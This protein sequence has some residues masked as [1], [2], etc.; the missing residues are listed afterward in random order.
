MISLSNIRI[1][2]A[3]IALVFRIVVFCSINTLLKLV[4]DGLV[5]QLIS[6][7]NPLSLSFA[8]A[9]DI[10]IHLMRIID[11]A[12][13]LSTRTELESL[14]IHNA[15][16]QQAVHETVI[17]QVLMPSEGYLRHLCVNHRLIVD[18]NQSSTF[19][20]LIAKIFKICPSHD[21]MVDFLCELPVFLA[22]PSCL[23]HFESFDTTL[24][25]PTEMLEVQ[26]E[27]TRGGGRMLRR[28][29]QVLRSLRTEGIEDVFE[30]RLPDIG[31][32]SDRAGVR[33]SISTTELHRDLLV[34]NLSAC[35]MLPNLTRTTRTQTLEDIM[36]SRKIILVAIWTVSQKID[37]PRQ[38]VMNC[39]FPPTQEDIITSSTLSER[40]SAHKF[41]L[42][43]PVRVKYNKLGVGSLFLR[44]ISFLWVR[45][46][47]SVS[48]IMQTP[49]IP[50]TFATPLC[51]TIASKFVAQFYS[52]MASHPIEL[53]RLY[54]EN[55][56]RVEQNGDDTFITRGTQEIRVFY[57]TAHP[58]EMAENFVQAVQFE[59]FVHVTVEG[60]MKQHQHPNRSFVHN[61][62]LQ[63]MNDTKK[64]FYIIREILHI[65]HPPVNPTVV[66]DLHPREKSPPLLTKPQPLTT[67][68]TPSTSAVQ[69]R[70]SSQ[71]SRQP[72]QQSRPQP[73]QP[74][75]TPPQ[76]PTQFS[77][78]PKQNTP[79]PQK[80][81]PNSS[82]KIF[83]PAARGQQLKPETLW[84]ELQKCGPINK[85]Y[86]QGWKTVVDF[87]SPESARKAMS[88]SH[89]VDGRLL[90]MAFFRLNQSLSGYQE[91]VK[92]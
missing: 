80:S 82:S 90:E 84:N 38:L 21:P 28:W 71:P 78:T 69:S 46:I 59:D 72:E 7:L 10:H 23:T 83:I 88:E 44:K 26:S 20:L 42:F 2:K 55:A 43:Q 6:A 53:T 47:Q 89:T 67:T 66:R 73:Q 19:I 30:Q 15:H 12:L 14:N 32:N 51:S 36:D 58:A 8:D 40:P 74:V 3:T 75:N 16:E 18:G 24:W 81:A 91:Y 57:Q 77:F 25:F 22:I 37:S 11:Y 33:R 86:Q 52:I 34:Q 4:S 56:V 31:W 79:P 41:K 70:E 29:N 63:Q 87:A 92:K 85:I 64:R 45:P 61:F 27:W 13:S 60:W 54:L 35:L 62:V 5:P 49:R 50:T 68:Y 48:L 76:Q 9:D 1:T 65:H 17:N 39:G